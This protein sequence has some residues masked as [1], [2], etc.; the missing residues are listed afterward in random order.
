MA[1]SGRNVFHKKKCTDVHYG[2]RFL[3]YRLN[4]YQAYV[5]LE[6]LYTATIYYTSQNTAVSHDFP[7]WRVCL[8]TKFLHLEIW[9]LS[10]KSPHQE[11]RW[12]YGILRSVHERSWL[13]FS[14]QC[15]M[16]YIRKGYDIYALKTVDPIFNGGLEKYISPFHQKCKK[17][18]HRPLVSP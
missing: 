12:K 13:K 8:S 5:V 9:C 14:K 2:M 15:L 6:T 4:S 18:N 17:Q 10:T 11:I 16:V 7:V 3:A 1:S